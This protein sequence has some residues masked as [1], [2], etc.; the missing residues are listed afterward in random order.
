MESDSGSS[1]LLFWAMIGGV[2]CVILFFVLRFVLPRAD[3]RPIKAGFRGTEGFY[4]GAV[5][6][7]SALPCGR[8]SSEAEQLY[9]MFAQRQLT[10]GEEGSMDLND[11]RNLLSKLTCFKRDLMSP[12]QTITAVK[13][14]GFAT[15]MDIQPIADLT[16]RCFSKT[17]PEREISIQ[18]IKWRDFGLSMI[19]RLCTASSMTESDVKSAEKLFLTTWNDVQDVAQT[20]CLKGP[21]VDPYTV[22]RYDPS[23]NTPEDVKSLRPYDGLY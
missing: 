1:S 23:A 18:F 20:Q 12:G 2:M 17:I 7:S 4:G 9:S 22:S 8:M 21:P 6:G 13:E 10:V 5:S 19:R 14:L 3:T 11:L 16:G 15:H